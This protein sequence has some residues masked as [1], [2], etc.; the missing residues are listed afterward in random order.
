MV[1][2]GAVHCL[3]NIYKSLVFMPTLI[4]RASDFGFWSEPS[5]LVFDFDAVAVAVAVA[6]IP[7]WLWFFSP[8]LSTMWLLE[9]GPP[10]PMLIS[11]HFPGRIF[12]GFRRLS[13]VRA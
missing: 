4:M 9:R 8:G 7:A 11:A 2:L 3:G 5:V 1:C 6:A 13:G 12:A 10:P